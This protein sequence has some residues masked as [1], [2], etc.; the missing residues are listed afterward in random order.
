VC[1][2]ADRRRLASSIHTH[3]QQH[4]RL[5]L[6]LQLAAFASA[7]AAAG[8]IQ[9][10]DDLALKGGPHVVCCL[11]AACFELLAESVYNREC[12]FGAKVGCL[13][14]SKAAATAAAATAAAAGAG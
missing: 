10:S 13:Q 5:P 9:Q 11:D 3:N 8:G 7:A 14:H 1:Q 2:L 12:S 4:S 6:Q